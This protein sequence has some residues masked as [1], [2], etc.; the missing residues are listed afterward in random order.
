MN[1][2]TVTP[3]GNSAVVFG[4]SI[5]GNSPTELYVSV[6]T[7]ILKAHPE[8][9]GQKEP[10]FTSDKA[11]ADKYTGTTRKVLINGVTVYIN[12][13]LSTKAKIKGIEKTCQLA[14]IG[15]EVSYD[16]LC[17]D[18]D[19]MDF[20]F[21][22]VFPS[23][24]TVQPVAKQTETTVKPLGEK[25]SIEEILIST[26]QNIMMMGTIMKSL[27]PSKGT[28]YAKHE[29]DY[30]LNNFYKDIKRLNYGIEVGGI[31][32]DNLG[33]WVL[34]ERKTPKGKEQLLKDS[35]P[36][37]EIPKIGKVNAYTLLKFAVAES[38]YKYYLIY[39]QN[40]TIYLH[41]MF[42]ETTSEI[43]KCNN[44]VRI[45]S[46]RELLL[47]T[48]ISDFQY[49]GRKEY[50]FQMGDYGY[51][52]DDY[53]ATLQLRVVNM[54]GNELIKVDNT[55]SIISAF[56]VRYDDTDLGKQ[57]SLLF[58]TDIEHNCYGLK[59]NASE[60]NIYEPGKEEWSFETA[61]ERDSVLKENDINY[62][63]YFKL[64]NNI[65]ALSTDTTIV[66]NDE[67]KKILGY[68]NKEFFKERK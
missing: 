7:E 35:I 49:V 51:T 40:N 52:S 64:K 67:Q 38:L 45:L 50:E 53:K 23:E 60:P 15:F 27:V 3:D 4:N 25:K 44:V 36:V 42:E 31:V 47:I 14:G 28:I 62:S 33:D 2:I 56:P 61:W 5:T 54:A 26:M 32:H 19:D 21:D 13:G 58:V 46:A 17:D 43:C 39:A 20:G 24:T 55:N 57:M 66:W 12:T 63:Q 65:V 22:T 11:R 10:H 34:G 37:Y 41:D 6:M 16:G 30:E 8:I 59:K 18:S 48:E 68:D 9:I 1:I 29:N